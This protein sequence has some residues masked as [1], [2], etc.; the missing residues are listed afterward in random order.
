MLATHETVTAAVGL[1]L[2]VFHDLT[3]TTILDLARRNSRHSSKTG[4]PQQWVLDENY[5]GCNNGGA[6]K[7]SVSIFLLNTN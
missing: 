7:M 3:V 6:G 1:V 5:A 2:N 4:F